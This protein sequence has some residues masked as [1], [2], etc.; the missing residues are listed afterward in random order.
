M[1][2]LTAVLLFS[3]LFGW[4]VGVQFLAAIGAVYCIYSAVS[5][6]RLK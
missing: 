5:Y 2:E 1:I 3:A 6:W 4:N